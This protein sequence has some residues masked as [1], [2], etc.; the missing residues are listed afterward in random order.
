MVKNQKRYHETKE[1]LSQLK[2]KKELMRT[3]KQREVLKERQELQ[4]SRNSGFLGT[5]PSYVK[6]SQSTTQAA[7][8]RPKAAAAGGVGKKQA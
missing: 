2:Q 5:K 8:G 4:E 3:E 6:S 1:L 7:R